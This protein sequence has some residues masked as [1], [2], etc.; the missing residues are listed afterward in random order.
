MFPL[1]S[2]AF[3]NMVP[4][5]IGKD[6]EHGLVG[7]RYV[8]GVGLGFQKPYAIPRAL[9]LLVVCGLGCVLSDAAQHHACLLPYILP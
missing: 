8:T 7:G 3:E 5:L 4:G 1:K 2:W 9:S 6:E